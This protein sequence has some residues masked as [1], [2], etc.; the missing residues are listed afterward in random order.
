LT[1]P[2]LT[3]HS[4][5]PS[6]SVISI[7]PGLFAR[8]MGSLHR[9]GYEVLSVDEL[10]SRFDGGERPSKKV[11]AITFDDGYA[12]FHEHAWPVLERYRFPAT[13]FLVSSYCGKPNAWPGPPS[14][15]GPLNLMSWPQ[16]REIAGSGIRIGAHTRSHPD[17]TRVDMDVAR[18]EIL[19]SKNDIED[20]AGVAASSFA[21]PYGLYDRRVR[22]IAAA[23]FDQAV[24]TRL[25]M[26]GSSSDRFA[27]ERIEMHYFR[28]P[29]LASRL[30]SPWL[31]VWLQARRSIRKVRAAVR[32]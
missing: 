31:S 32:R 28:N 12:N 3:Y 13:V 17:L 15:A 20:R 9:A 29:D 26:A 23:A 4:L 10:I 21:Y 24:S 5:D 2:I 30:E 1:V 7:P 22:D 16:I 14:P 25:G 8:Q 18:T 19:G 27:L 6:G 11:L